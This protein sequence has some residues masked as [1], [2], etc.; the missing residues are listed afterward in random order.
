MS[1]IYFAIT[2]ESGRILEGAKGQMAF[3]SKNFAVRSIGQT[4]VKRDTYDIVE[5][6]HQVLAE[7]VC[8]EGKTYE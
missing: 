8:E 7:F 3:D 2:K 1:N 4:R 5:I 6:P